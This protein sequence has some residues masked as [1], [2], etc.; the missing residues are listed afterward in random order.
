VLFDSKLKKAGCASGAHS[1]HGKMHILD[2]MVDFV[3]KE[4]AVVTQALKPQLE[5]QK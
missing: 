5:K 2:L 1:D 3:P 4:K